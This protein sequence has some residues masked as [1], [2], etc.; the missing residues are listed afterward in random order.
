MKKYFWIFFILVTA[1]LGLENCRHEPP[2]KPKTTNNPNDPDSLYAGTKTT[3]G[4]ISPAGTFFFGTPV[5]PYIDSLTV[6]GIQLGRRLFY[7]K[8][9]SLDGHK[10]CASCHQLQY[11]YADSGYALSINEF[12]LTKRNAIPLQNMAWEPSFFGTGGNPL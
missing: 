6:E 7:D 5:N 4:A 12:G 3:F 2:V 9:L 10:S 11:A 8:H 1:V